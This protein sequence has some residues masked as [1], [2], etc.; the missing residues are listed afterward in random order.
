MSVVCASLPTRLT[1]HCHSI[2]T[3]NGDNT[4]RSKRRGNTIPEF[5]DRDQLQSH[6]AF[7]AFDTCSLF[8][9]LILFVV[10]IESPPFLS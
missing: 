3:G 7:D 4:G 2:D 8:M 1:H 6:Q 10:L 5:P 9:N